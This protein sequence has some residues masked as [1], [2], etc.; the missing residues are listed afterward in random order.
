MV[1]LSFVSKDNE[2]NRN[3]SKDKRQAMA[4]GFDGL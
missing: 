1:A 3:L 4:Y 2:A